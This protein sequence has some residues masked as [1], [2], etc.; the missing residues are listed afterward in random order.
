MSIVRR[1]ARGLCLVGGLLVSAQPADSC[2]IC[3]GSRIR[4]PCFAEQII[5]ADRLAVARAGGH[6][7][8][9]IEA[10]LRGAHPEPG[11]KVMIDQ[12][13]IGSRVLLA[14]PDD[15]SLPIHLGPYSAELTELMRLIF[16]LKT[17]EPSSESGWSKQ[18]ET[19]RPYLSHRDPRISS[20]AWTAWALAPYRVLRRQRPLPDRDILLSW[21]DDPT[22]AGEASL[23][24]T[25]LGLQADRPI[26]ARLR[27]TI[28][29]SWKEN[30]SSH[31]AALLD[32]ELS[33]SGPRAIDFIVS[34]YIDD[35]DR[36][37][38][39][40]QCALLALSM[41]ANEGDPALREPIALAFEAFVEKRRPLSGLVALDLQKWQ[42][43]SVAKLYAEILESGE[44]VYPSSRPAILSYLE[45][46]RLGNE[47]I[48]RASASER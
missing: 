7:S 23:Y 5:Q 47:L 13:S 26:K 43:W 11:T 19:F 2:P 8:F 9:V 29:T 18:L 28:L 46:S 24:W 41:H 3:F 17:L 45:G 10:R 15:D 30:D 1:L 38:D 35:R 12:P 44:P 33:A 31:L 22:R 48:N 25:L 32:A 20:S 14:F 40:I 39:E 37:L 42:R 4:P 21:L 27:R 6:G 16:P 36:T 34:R